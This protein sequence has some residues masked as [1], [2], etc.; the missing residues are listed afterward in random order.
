MPTIVTY[1]RCATDDPSSLDSRQA[2]LDSMCELSLL[3]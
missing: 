2:E 3:P 1:F